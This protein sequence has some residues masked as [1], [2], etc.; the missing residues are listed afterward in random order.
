VIERC[1]CPNKIVPQRVP[2]LHCALDRSSQLLVLFKLSQDR[3]QARRLGFD[4]FADIES[5]PQMIIYKWRKRFSFVG[6]GRLFFEE[7]LEQQA[8]PK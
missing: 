8:A 4:L 7:A 2:R 1:R 6:F 5:G 3:L